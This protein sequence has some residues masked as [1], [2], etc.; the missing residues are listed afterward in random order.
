MGN[1]PDA[2]H[3][4]ACLSFCPR[5][6]RPASGR[7][8]GKDSSMA[9]SFKRLHGRLGGPVL[10]AAVAAF[11]LVRIVHAADGD[12]DVTFGNGGLVV[13]DFGWPRDGGNGLAVDG[14]GRVIVAGQTAVPGESHVA[15]ARYTIGGVLDSAFGNN[16]NVTTSIG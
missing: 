16:G 1:P 6:L 15:I 8:P 14:N 5:I 2:R 7:S 11:A 4:T 13:T 12:L 3:P 10:C 9:T